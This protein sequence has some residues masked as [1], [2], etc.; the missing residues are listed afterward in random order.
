MHL[1]FAALLTGF[2]L[3]ITGATGAA[4]RS[5]GPQ[6]FQS[7]ARGLLPGA[8]SLVIPEHTPETPYLRTF[9]DALARSLGIDLQIKNGQV[10]LFTFHT[11]Q[12]DTLALT[13]GGGS[14]GTFLNLRWQRG[15]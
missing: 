3:M 7:Q 15:Q 6:D 14:S 4:E 9:A 10:D 11:T 8:P 5:V 13:A 1:P 2:T 12:S